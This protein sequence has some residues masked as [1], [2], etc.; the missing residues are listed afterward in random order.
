MEKSDGLADA[1]KQEVRREVLVARVMLRQYD[2]NLVTVS[3]TDR[4]GYD[5]VGGASLTPEEAVVVAQAL[6]EYAETGTLGKGE[7]YANQ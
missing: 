3:V 5:L 1:C 6:L 4:K 2:A 7:S